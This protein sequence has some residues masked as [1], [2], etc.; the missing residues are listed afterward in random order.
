MR[1][2]YYSNLKSQPMYL[3]AYS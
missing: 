2:Y 1:E 3:S